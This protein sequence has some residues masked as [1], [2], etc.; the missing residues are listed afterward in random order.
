[1]VKLRRCLT[2]IFSFV[3]ALGVKVPIFKRN[4]PIDVGA[5]LRELAFKYSSGKNSV[6]I[7][8]SKEDFIPLSNYMNAQFFGPISLGTPPQSFQVIFDTGSSNLWV[9]SSK[10]LF[11]FH[12]K[13]DGSKSSTYRYNGTSFSITYG[14]GSLSGY[15]GQDSLGIGDITVRDQVFGEA[16]AEP[17]ITFVLGKFDGILGLGWPS[18]AVKGVIPP[19]QNML[20]Q[21]LVDR[22][23]FSF[24]LPSDTKEKGELDIGGIDVSK[25]TGNLT[26]VPLTS[27]TYWKIKLDNI[28]FSG[29]SFSEVRDAIVDTGTSL[30]T[31]PT[32]EIRKFA[33]MIGAEPGFG[34]QLTLNCSQISHYPTLTIDIGGNSFPLTAAQ[35]TLN[36]QGHCVLGLAGL[37]LASP[38]GP[39]WILGDIFIREYYTVFDVD[40]ARIGM[41]PISRSQQLA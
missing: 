11:C 16:T 19:M 36:F 31:G 18:I 14:S 41:A 21:N 34:G 38:A 2:F 10:C 33:S 35:Y 23:V 8:T 30:I 13:F 24:Y 1:M 7:M 22:G 6:D 29:R 17:G 40:K 25:F 3:S 26:W 20:A 39:L 27:R 5:A 4:D 12:R 9:P 32:A 15:L 37:D 28:G